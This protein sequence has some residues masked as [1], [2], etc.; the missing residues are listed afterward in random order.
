MLDF[1]PVRAREKTLQDL[2]SGLGRDELVALTNEMINRELQLI[3][4]AEDSDVTFV[5]EDPD[6]NDTFATSD[7]DVNLAWTLGHVV[8][9]T[10]AS[11]EEAAA[12]A[13]TL[14]RGLEVAGRSRSEVP[15]TE[16]TSVEFCRQRLEESRRMRLAM[17]AAWPDRPNLDVTYQAAPGRTPLNA[18]ARFLG[19]LMHDDSH[20]DQIAK[21]VDQA[22]AARAPLG[23]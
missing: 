4:P 18:I 15:W 10:T 11:S 21:I 3:V 23:R 16:A 19:G 6:A 14:A 5:P 1:Q 9:H 17:L 13:L 7:G 2:A 20:L 8:V 12:H 22:R